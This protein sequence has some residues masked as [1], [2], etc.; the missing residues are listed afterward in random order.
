MQI[1]RFLKRHKK[2]SLE[3]GLIGKRKIFNKCSWKNYIDG[4]NNET[5]LFLIVNKNKLEMNQKIKEK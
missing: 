1:Y 4:Q 3:K 5:K 2:D